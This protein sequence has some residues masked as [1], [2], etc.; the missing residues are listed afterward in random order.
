MPPPP[1]LGAVSSLIIFQDLASLETCLIRRPTCLQ[2]YQRVMIAGK[3]YCI[4][5]SGRAYDTSS[6]IHEQDTAAA[7]FER[8]EREQKITGILQRFGVVGSAQSRSGGGAKVKRPVSLQPQPQSQALPSSTP[9][10][11]PL[12]SILSSSAGAT[13]GIKKTVHF[14]EEV[15]TRDFTQ[16]AA[17]RMEQIENSVRLLG[18]MA[19]RI[20]WLVAAYARQTAANVKAVEAKALGANQR[21]AQQPGEANDMRAEYLEYLWR[22]IVPAERKTR[23]LERPVADLVREIHE[24]VSRVKRLAQGESARAE[25]RTHC[26]RTAATLLTEISYKVRQCKK[27][28]N[29]AK[30]EWDRATVVTRLAGLTPDN[31]QQVQMYTEG[32]YDDELASRFQQLFRAEDTLGA[33]VGAEAL[34]ED[35]Q[36]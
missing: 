21:A 20:E 26:L 4:S 9:S 5:P 35:E 34:A 22:K 19:S 7:F 16:S 28:C 1:T 17:E 29:V 11:Q 31:P 25:L 12:R 2:G 36:S 8:T 30:G 10:L 24:S 15:D 13:G 32:F 27:M 14:S 23:D 3:I 6:L 33:G 18:R